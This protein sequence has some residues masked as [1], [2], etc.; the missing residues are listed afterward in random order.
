MS[1]QTFFNKFFRLWI[2]TNLITDELAGI[3]GSHVLANMQKIIQYYDI[4]EKGTEFPPPSDSDFVPADLHYKLIK[5]LIDKEARFLFAKPPEYFVRP[6]D[7]N[8]ASVQA[9]NAYQSYINNIIKANGLGGKMVKAA[10]DCLIGGRIAIFIDFNHVSGIK[11]SLVP[12]LEFVYEVDEYGDM[13]KIIA[14]F[15]LNDETEKGKQR[16]Q[17]KKYWLE[18]GKCHVS[19]GI[20][21]GGGNLVE[22]L[23]DDLVTEF[24]YI[25]A[26]VI[27]N[28]A[29]L[30]D[31]E[32][33]SDM[34]GIVDYEEY[35][36]RLSNLDI[37]SERQGMN[38]IR[39]VMDV[40]PKSTEK[41]KST[42]KSK[43][44]VAAGSL[45]DLK[46]DTTVN[47]NANGKV[48]VLENNMS[49]SAP[50]STTLSRI[51][52]SM[53]EQL[54]VPS[55]TPEDLKGIVTSGKTLKAIYWD[56]IVRCDEKMLDWRPALEFMVKCIIDGAKLYPEIAK[57]YIVDPLQE[58]DYIITVDNQYPLPEDEAEEKEIDMSEVGAKVRS[59]K[60]YMK[61][62][63]NMTDDEADKEIQQIAYERQILEDSYM[64]EMSL[65]NGA[66]QA[67][68]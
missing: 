18:N 46:S 55:V 11:I 35:Y 23:I 42:G 9:C 6:T 58:V 25:P 8:E 51:R 45:W 68:Q 38:P 63:H 49:Y 5:M 60:S 50:L 22:T 16:L 21:D 52:N 39:Y 2:P 33:K 47:D 14:F 1:M 32:G 41:S 28:N 29:L 15:A 36:N 40:S 30:G 4:Y 66:T 56:L 53:F 7:P 13:N 19:E 37:D 20:Y 12:A 54:A 64:P 34:E 59:L 26:V 48:G 27:L 57:R 17:R 24:E 44:T 62:W 31:T 43:L 3:Y 10:K 61:K 65:G 67:K